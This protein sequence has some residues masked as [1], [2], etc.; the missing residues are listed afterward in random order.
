M[1]ADPIDATS[2]TG[3]ATKIAGGSIMSKALTDAASHSALTGL[4]STFREAALGAASMKA[5][6]IG[7]GPGSA[8]YAGL[9]AARYLTT[10]DA[11]AVTPT[12]A[13]ETDAEAID[14]RGDVADSV[15]LRPEPMR[16]TSTELLATDTP[17]EKA[18]AAA[19]ATAWGAFLLG[20]WLDELE[21]MNVPIEIAVFT[22]ISGLDFI[23]GQMRKRYFQT[24]RLMRT[25]RR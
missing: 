16:A 2:I 18:L 20:V 12:R 17:T 11:F 3:L 15:L 22:L 14:L 21:R 6:S 7:F 23:V 1:S 25:L 5:F 9:S 4:T 19:A 10:T 24:L 13:L 8:G